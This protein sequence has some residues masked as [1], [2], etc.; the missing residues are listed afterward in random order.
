MVSY[1]RSKSRIRR[2]R[3]TRRRMTGGDILPEDIMYQDNDVCILRPEVKKG[4]LVFSNYVQPKNSPSLC[5][6]GLKSGKQLHN[7][8]INFGRVVYHPY[9]FFR[10]PFYANP[11][12]YSSIDSEIKSSFGKD[13]GNRT[14]VWIRVDPDRTYIYSSELRM[15]AARERMLRA[16]RKS[17]TNYLKIIGE[18]RS[19][20]PGPEQVPKYHLVSSQKM[21]F[22]KGF[23]N[24]NNR[25]NNI[26]YN[27]PINKE[28]IERNSEVLVAINH[29]TPEYFV[30]CT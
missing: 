22:P 20:V 7:E 10:A 1:T 15:S 27:S 23:T 3:K 24:N 2:Y 11:I 25:F 9:I 28:P 14:R 12:D 6:T 18:N 17:M 26:N 13:L 30:R 16:S 8:G 5:E 4:I 29:L 19:I 21:L